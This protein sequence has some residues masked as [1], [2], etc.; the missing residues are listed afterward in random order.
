MLTPKI[1]KQ[2]KQ[3]AHHLHPVVMLGHHGLTP[4]VTAETD[5]A[6]TAHEL[7][8]VKINGADRE[9]R[10][11]MTKALCTATGADLVQSIGNMAV[12]YRVNP[13]KD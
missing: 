12:L 7:I 6:L 5:S 2:L 4:A 10:A 1:K 13:D 11:E 3:Q 9:Q 8:K